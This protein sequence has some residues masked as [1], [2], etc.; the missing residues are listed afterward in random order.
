MYRLLFLSALLISTHSVSQHVIVY[1][2][3]EKILPAGTAM[4]FF[5]DSTGQLT[6]NDI[7]ND[8]ARYKF[9]SQHKT[10]PN[11]SI[12]R[13]AIWGRFT[14]RN[15]T[16]ESCYIFIE[17]ARLHHINFYYP[18]A[19]GSFTS[20]ASGFFHHINNRDISANF[21]YFKLLPPN[22]QE[23]N[24]FYFQIKSA[25]P[26]M[27]PAVIGSTSVLSDHRYTNGTMTGLIWGI[28]LATALY[29][30]IIFIAIRERSYLYHIFHISA[31][32]VI[33]DMNTTGI[34]YKH[35][36]N[37]QPYLNHYKDVF[38]G[39]GFMTAVAFCTSF[40][41]TRQNMPGLHKGLLVF[42]GVAA[43]IILLSLSR[44]IYAGNVII[45]FSGFI[46][47]IYLIV[48]AAVAYRKKITGS[49]Y[50]LV[51]WSF[52]LVSVIV[53][54]LMLNGFVPVVFPA[55]PSVF[56]IN[57]VFEVGTVAEIVTI[58]IALSHR[59][60]AIRRE[61][62]IAQS[63]KIQMTSQVNESLRKAVDERTREIENQHRE[64]LSQHEELATQHEVILTQ[65][66]QL[67]AQKKELEKAKETI[68]EQNEKL[69]VYAASLEHKIASR[70][71]ELENINKELIHQNHV[72]QQFSYTAAHNLRAPVARLLG[73]T[74][75]LQRINKT[76]S[77][78]ID[79]T[80]KIIQTSKDLDAIIHDMAD[81][82]EI[83]KGSGRQF[84][85]VSLD[86]KMSTVLSLLTADIKSSGAI[87]RYDFKVKTLQTDPAYIESIFYNLISNSIKYKS[88][89]RT[90]VIDIGS[91]ISGEQIQIIF[92]DN[93]IGLD[94]E[95]FRDK[96]FGLYQRFNFNV[97]GR[98]LGLHLVKSQVEAL[99]GTID[100]ESK[101][102]EG[103]RFIIS[104]PVR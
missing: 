12:T 87:V 92:Q 16:D 4:Y 84:V 36:F 96:I 74:N 13:N 39:L 103:T 94:V 71:I 65:N 48:I 89:T 95:R 45:N 49:G 57:Y 23:A 64:I 27:L 69:T 58:S 9:K 82:L 38:I 47:S 30:F 72:L 14:V 102:D 104:F 20:T 15:E 2:N 52:L 26:I 81:I 44:F 90:P 62:E 80:E 43:L 3:P 88:L 41:N 78:E 19:D 86:E 42:Y 63:E 24:T 67:E 32:L 77:E 100:I 50:Y 79:I 18:Q 75:L 1:Q 53:S 6:L 8:S 91:I 55:M 97:E 76:D 83:R 34:L 25:E 29:N 7:L 60:R 33:L 59:V 70:T 10:V 37:G 22:T 46:L 66:S 56:A 85:E 17:Y 68:S 61:K 40:L 101:I 99:G 54:I 31:M 73:L 35:I 5:S 21:F 11:F 98:G 28:V 51:G 93:G